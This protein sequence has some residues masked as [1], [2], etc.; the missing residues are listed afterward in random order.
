MI[1]IEPALP[2]AQLISLPIIIQE[3]AFLNVFLYL[4]LLNS[5]MEQKEFVFCSVL[6][7]IFQ[8]IAQENVWINAQKHQIILLTGNL[9]PVFQYAPKLKLHYIMLINFQGLV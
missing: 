9:E 5:W 1:Q 2:N 4:Q 7:D 8:I 3:G 6:L